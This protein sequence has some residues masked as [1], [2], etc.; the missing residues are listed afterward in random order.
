MAST[1]RE[2][3]PVRAI[4]GTVLP[5]APGPLTQAAAGALRE[6]IEDALAAPTTR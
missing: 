6:H 4:D 3:H 2:V 5:A 1:L